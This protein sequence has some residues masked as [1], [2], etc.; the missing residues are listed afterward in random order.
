M[1]PQLFVEWLH[2]LF[3]ALTVTKNL[4]ASKPKYLLLCGF[5]AKEKTSS[6]V[7]WEIFAAKNF[8]P[9]A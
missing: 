7:D 5:D 4:E 9:V 6:T 3:V 1:A 2:G 8:S